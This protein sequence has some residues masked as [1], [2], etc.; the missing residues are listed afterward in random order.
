MDYSDYACEMIIAVNEV[1][2]ALGL[3]SLVV[4]TEEQLEPSTVGQWKIDEVMPQ[5]KSRGQKAIAGVLRFTGD[6]AVYA[7]LRI[8]G[9]RCERLS[10][11]GDLPLPGVVGY[12]FSACRLDSRVPSA[13]TWP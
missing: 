8:E 9:Y 2:A 6:E 11:K 13:R 7:P 4:H 5:A 3:P 1:R 12:G 10:D